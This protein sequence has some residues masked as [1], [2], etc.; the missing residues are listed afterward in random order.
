MVSYRMIRGKQKNGQLE[1]DRGKQKNIKME[2]CKHSQSY[3]TW[4]PSW[5]IWKLGLKKLI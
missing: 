3:G 1:N 4:E 2:M 5:Y